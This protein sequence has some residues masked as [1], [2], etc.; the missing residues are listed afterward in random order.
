M[1]ANDGQ[2]LQAL[3]HRQISAT[4]AALL[5][6]MQPRLYGFIFKRLADRDQTLEVLQRTNLVIC[7]K[8]ADFV[9]GTNFDAWAFTIAR[10]QLMAWRK[11]QATSRLVFTDS[12]Y[13]LFDQDT[14]EEAASAAGNLEVLRQCLKKLRPQDLSLVHQRYRD[15]RPLTAIAESLEKSIDAVGMRLSRIRR[16][17]S[18]CIQATIRLQAL[19]E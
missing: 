10:F 13:D 11:T 12:V 2:H 14:T 17:L 4:V 6:T 16:Q 9:T 3:G 1:A 7:E 15:S 8:A 18:D 19:D 5:A